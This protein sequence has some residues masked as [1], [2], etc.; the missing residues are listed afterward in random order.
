[1]F[2]TDFIGKKV[3]SY[4][5]KILGYTR[6]ACFSSDYK[7]I[8]ALLCSDDEEEDFLI[9][10]PLKKFDDAVI[11]PKTSASV[12]V[13]P[14]FYSPISRPVYSENGAFLGMVTD[15]LL[16]KSRPVWLFLKEK[17]CLVS[18]VTAFGDC[19]LLRLS[20]KTKTD[21]S[22]RTLVRDITDENGNIVFFKGTILSPNVLKAATAKKRLVELTAR[23]FSA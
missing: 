9:P 15:V 17:R 5:G 19:I 7:K 3:C 6:S 2:L 12:G 10:F 20:G 8:T 16:E 11:L 14:L 4:D 21:L 22:G 1:M 13:N 23:S 18:D